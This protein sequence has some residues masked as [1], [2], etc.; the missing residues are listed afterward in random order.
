MAGTESD[1]AFLDYRHHLGLGRHEH[2][3]AQ[4][5]PDRCRSVQVRP[6]SWRSDAE[7]Q[8][9]SWSIGVLEWW[10]TGVIEY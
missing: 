10:S 6:P 8:E 4:V 2:L 5:T 3:E 9:K 1:C 7:R